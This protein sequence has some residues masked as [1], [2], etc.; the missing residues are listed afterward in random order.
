MLPP[1]L[2]VPPPPHTPTNDKHCPNTSRPNHTVADMRR[3]TT[4]LETP[5]RHPT[6]VE[7]AK[8]APN[9]H[10]AK[11]ACLQPP[12]RKESTPCT[13]S[14]SEGFKSSPPGPH[15]YSQ[16]RPHHHR[17]PKGRSPRP[18]PLDIGHLLPQQFQ[19]VA[20]GLSFPHTVVEPAWDTL[21]PRHLPHPTS[22]DV[23]SPTAGDLGQ[24]VFGPALRDH[25][26]KRRLQAL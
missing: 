9:S 1:S 12:C 4:S 5:R 7:S 16:R 10:T 25:N 19:D 3:P 23:R 18:V 15:R 21:A 22:V 14:G 17:G 2:C 20:Q 24:V 6:N 13:S 8:A 11:A 26:R